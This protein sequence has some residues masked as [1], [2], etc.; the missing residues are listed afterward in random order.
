MRV[1]KIE[2]HNFAVGIQYERPRQLL[3][4]DF[5]E[6]FAIG[7]DEIWKLSGGFLERLAGGVIRLLLR[8]PDNAHAFLAERVD[9]I[10]PEVGQLFTRH[11]TI[12]LPKHDHR[13]RF[14]IEVG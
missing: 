1:F 14:A 3:S 9:D 2:P 7:V 10:W 5:R 12:A 8:D 11:P 6:S 13:R 4:A